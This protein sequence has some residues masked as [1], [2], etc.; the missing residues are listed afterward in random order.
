L[1]PYAIKI[2]RLRAGMDERSTLGETPWKFT[3]NAQS[4]K[5]EI[6]RVDASDASG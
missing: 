3:R 4:Q 6:R 1:S 5:P 2:E